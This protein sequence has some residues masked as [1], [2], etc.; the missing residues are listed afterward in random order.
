M[1]T[2]RSLQKG[3]RISRKY[4]PYTL[5]YFIDHPT[6]LRPGFSVRG[7][8]LK[9]ITKFDNIE[10]GIGNRDAKSMV[11]STRRLIELSFLAALDSGIQY[12]GKKFGSFMC[13]TS[14]ENFEAVRVA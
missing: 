10:F 6:L 3:S 11:M 2:A 1:L 5:C 8:F 4:T 12:R 7:T 13:G 14:V 9:Q